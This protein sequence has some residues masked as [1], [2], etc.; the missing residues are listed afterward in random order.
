MRRTIS[1]W[2]SKVVHRRNLTIPIPVQIS[3]IDRRNLRVGKATTVRS[4]KEKERER[5]RK[6]NMETL[7]EGSLKAVVKEKAESV[8]ILLLRRVPHLD[9]LKAGVK[10]TFLLASVASHVLMELTAAN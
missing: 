7:K 9:L 1:N 6:G 8:L 10:G 3:A 5:E 2:F 4:R